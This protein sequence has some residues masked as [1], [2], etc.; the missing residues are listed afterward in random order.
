MLFVSEMFSLSRRKHSV[1]GNLLKFQN[2]KRLI[3]RKPTS[4]SVK[5]HRKTITSD[6]S[7]YFVRFFF[8]VVVVDSFW[9][10]VVVT[11]ASEHYIY[12]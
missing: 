10:F 2:S 12:D 8:V 1:P 11:C 6:S 4:L 9:L 3:L 5:S 7:V